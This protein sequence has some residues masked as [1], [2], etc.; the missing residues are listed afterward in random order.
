MGILKESKSISRRKADLSALE[1][2]DVDKAGRAR[3]E[4]G[5]LEHGGSQGG[6]VGD[7]VELFG[8]KI[9]E[10]DVE[11]ED[12]FDG[13]DGRVG[14]EEVRHGS[15]VDGADGYGL[16]GEPHQSSSVTMDD[17]FMN[18]ICPNS[19]SVWDGNRLSECFGVNA[20][21]LV[22]ISIIGITHRSPP[23]SRRINMLE[24]LFLHFLPAFGAC[25]SF[26]DVVLIL[27][28]AL[29]GGF[30]VHHE[31]FFKCSQ[32][33][34]WT[35]ILLF[36]KSSNYHYI[37]C[38]L[39][40]C[41]WWIVKPILGII[42]LLATLSSLG[43][44]R[45]LKESCVVLLDIMFGLSINIIRIKRTSS[46]SSSIEESLLST[47]KD[48]EE[49]CHMDSGNSQSYWDL[50]TFKSITSVM[51]HGVTK[52]LDFEDLLRL[53]ADMD[54]LSCHNRLLSCWQDQQIKNCSNPSLF[55]AICSAYGWPYVRLGLLK[56]LNDC[57]GF[58]GPLLLNKLIRFLQQGS[59]HLDGYVLA[60]SLG[61]TSVLKSFFDTQYSFHLSK[62]KLKLRSGIMT[63][64][65]QK[66]VKLLMAQR[67]RGTRGGIRGNQM[68]VGEGVEANPPVG[69][70]VGRNQ[71]IEREDVIAELRR[72]VT[73]LTEVVQRMQ[74]PHETTDESNDSHSH[75]ENPFG[76]PP[77]GRPYVERNEPRLDYNFKW[78][79][80]H[81][82]LGNSSTNGRGETSG[83]EQ[84][85][86]GS[87][88]AI[89]APKQS[90]TATVGGG[91]QQ[92]VGTFKCFK[93]G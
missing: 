16:A 66:I 29:H 71:N 35:S 17:F 93:C 88:Y 55:R 31:W 10:E 49:G 4:A 43:I 19:P 68:D 44:L 20:I 70:N 33:A 13:V 41:F 86:A 92:Q 24:R 50:M 77:R 72:Q 2:N 69:R 87:K 53:P 30:I 28:K 82:K 11:G 25:L 38:N 80:S 90:Q 23:R 91:R 56:V 45:C 39:I 7:L 54:P 47:D 81:Y 64:I 57:I 37:F 5:G 1:V 32:F 18:L 67:R 3:G 21:T 34:V 6:A 51:N 36:S 48:L 75:F 83:V 73:A 27:I 40:L 42:Y 61:L 12:V 58:A 15:V 14:G 9:V 62:L 76:A 52:Q 60:M 84:Q 63:V 59:G 46:R 85:P 8:A 79:S 22:M 89:T 26:L 74:P 65:Y 78:I